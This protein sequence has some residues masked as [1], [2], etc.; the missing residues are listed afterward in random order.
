MPLAAHIRRSLE[1]EAGGELPEKPFLDA[2]EDE[3][4]SQEGRRVMGVVVEWGR[5]GAV[6]EYDF[7]TGRLELPGA[8]EE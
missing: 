7:H 3:L 2:L 5:Y 6:F 8:D 1:Q 4:G